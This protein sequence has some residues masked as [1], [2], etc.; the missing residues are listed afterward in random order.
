MRIIADIADWA[1]AESKVEGLRLTRR[2]IYNRQRRNDS[3][4]AG[5]S[6]RPLSRRRPPLSLPSSSPS[7]TLNPLILLTRHP[8][9]PLTNPQN[10]LINPQKPPPPPGFSPTWASTCGSSNCGRR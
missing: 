10:P 2:V 4:R 8:Q 3:R 9:N 6:A 1:L 5:C 7:L